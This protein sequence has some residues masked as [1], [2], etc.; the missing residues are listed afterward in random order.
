[1]KVASYFLNVYN[2]FKGNW[3]VFAW[4]L[5][6]VV[7]VLSVSL[8]FLEVTF[9]IRTLLGAFTPCRLLGICLVSPSCCRM[10]PG[11]RS[12]TFFLVVC[13][14]SAQILYCLNAFANTDASGKYLHSFYQWICMSSHLRKKLNQTHGKCCFLFFFSQKCCIELNFSES[15]ILDCSNPYNNFWLS[16]HIK[17]IQ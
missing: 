7:S 3:Q 12:N 9:E 14:K 17:Q 11:T 10:N 6:Y 5:D 15:L 8:C 16:P 13:E 4:I 2:I 1:M